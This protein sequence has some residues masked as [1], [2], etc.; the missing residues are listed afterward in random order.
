MTEG[1]TGAGAAY[2]AGF[3]ATVTLHEREE[4]ER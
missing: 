4:G 2:W 1:E 3:S